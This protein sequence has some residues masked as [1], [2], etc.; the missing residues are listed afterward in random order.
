MEVAWL[1]IAPTALAG[2]NSDSIEAVAF[3]TQKVI[4]HMRSLSHFG[5]QV[6]YKSASP[7]KR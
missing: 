5:P 2:S 4:A 1:I 6:C 7:H 3:G